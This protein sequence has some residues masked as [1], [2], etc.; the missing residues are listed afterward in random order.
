MNAALS[1]QPIAPCAVS[2]LLA[3]L[4][5]INA[6]DAGAKC[7]V[8]SSWGRLLRLVGGA[9]KG[10][11]VEFAAMMGAQHGPGGDSL[12]SR[13]ARP[14]APATPAAAAAIGRLNQLHTR[15]LHRHQL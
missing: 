8:F 7:V 13:A 15:P 4:A 12:P 2:A 6:A 14:R 10:N 1:K 9:L 11:G 5:D 3:R